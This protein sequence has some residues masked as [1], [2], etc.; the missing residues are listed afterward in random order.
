MEFGDGIWVCTEWNVG[1]RCDVIC[2]RGIPSCEVYMCVW[3]EGGVA[4]W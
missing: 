2:A 4:H 3:G 1:D